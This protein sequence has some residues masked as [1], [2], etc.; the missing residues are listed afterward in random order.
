MRPYCLEFLKTISKY[1]EVFIFTAA[2]ESYA[3]YIIDVLDPENKCI[4]GILF[5]DH[6]LQTKKGISIKDLGI[7]KNRELKNMV[8]IDNNA[9][10]FALQLENGIPILEW[11]DDKND[12]ELKYILHY[13][14]ELSRSDDVRT[15]NKKFLKLEELSN[16]GYRDF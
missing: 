9:H 15:F 7:I 12:R 1:Y 5:R 4:R 16:L 2:S 14:M 10:S 13:L 11:K 8:I 3:N 6:C